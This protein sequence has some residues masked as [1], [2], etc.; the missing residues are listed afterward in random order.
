MRNGGLQEGRPSRQ[1]C[2]EP[3]GG[4]SYGFPPFHPVFDAEQMDC[5]AGG[6]RSFPE[7]SHTDEV[8]PASAYSHIPT[9]AFVPSRMCLS[10]LALSFSTEYFT[11]YLW[12]V[13]TVLLVRHRCPHP[14]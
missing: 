12:P 11:D 2:R 13:T 14:N 8:N 3:E 1:R 6:Y 5:D 4:Q 10:M 9:A 7:C